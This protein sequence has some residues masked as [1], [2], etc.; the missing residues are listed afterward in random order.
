MS[1]T[2]WVENILREYMDGMDADER[3]TWIDDLE[4]G[5]CSSGMVMEL[6]TYHKA[7][8]LYNRVEGD[9]LSLLENYDLTE[10]EPKGETFAA[11]AV[12]RLS[13]AFEASARSVFE[14]MAFEDEGTRDEDEDEGTRDEDES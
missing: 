1:D 14:D 2:Y 4:Y 5:G 8:E 9:V 3:E 11:L 7:L 6:V 10:H 12:W 13:A